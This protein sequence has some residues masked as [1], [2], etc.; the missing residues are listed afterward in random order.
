MPF[1]RLK[2]IILVSFFQ[3]LTLAAFAQSAP[4]HIWEIQ[5]NGT[6][7]PVLHQIVTTRVSIVTAVGSNCFFIQSPPQASDHDPLTS[8]GV[9]VF[10]GFRPGLSVG[11]SVVVTGIVQE[12]ETM[13]QIGP[14]AL[15]I[16]VDTSQLEMPQPI[17]F[18]DSFPGD[19]AMEVPALEAIEGMRVSFSALSTAPITANN[20]IPVSARMRRSFRE[21]GIRHPGM[22]DLPVWDGNPEVFWVAPNALGL[23][24]DRFVGAHATLKGSGVLQ[25]EGSRYVIWP[26]TLD[27]AAPTLFEP[28]AAPEEKA[29]T[30][31]SLNAVLLREDNFFLDDNLVKTA[32]YIIAGMRAPK[33]I[34]LQEIGN[35]YILDRLAATLRSLDPNLN[36]QPVFRSGNDNIHLAFL[37]DAALKIVEVQQIG[38]SE[39]LDNGQLLH[40][41]PPLLLELELPTDPATRLFVL[42]VHL[43]SLI[44]VDHPELG[45][46]V[47]NKRHAQGLSVAK[48]VQNY[49]G[50]NLVVLGDFNAYAFTDGY[51][52]VLGQITGRDGLG[53][54]VPM[55]PIVYP[56]LN[57]LSASLPD[58][59]QYSYNYEGNAE[60]LDHCLS[61]DLPDFRVIRLQYAR[62]NADNAWD[63]LKDP[64]T[65]YRSSDHDG[66]VLFLEPLR[67]ILSS[68]TNVN[69]TNTRVF[70][71]NPF[72]ADD[73]I[74]I[75]FERSG[76]NNALLFNAA[77][78]LVFHRSLKG[79]Q[80]VFQLPELP[81]GLYFLRISGP[82]QFM[83]KKL[84]L[85]QQ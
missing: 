13:T 17:V 76:N 79:K 12:Y 33:V 59:Q 39:R 37:V 65:P 56:Y 81:A 19:L 43:R 69:R 66:L 67:P 32:R 62:G 68:T 74:R 18:S 20:R 44:N 71:P 9:K 61:N 29:L 80:E 52:D 34:A 60:L 16:R 24:L 82:G 28:V 63:H 7:S 38:L 27:I 58:S 15:S 57:N 50:Q 55:E 25:A 47:R 8:D 64:S 41:R 22:S 48:V 46:Q 1:K 72:G 78:Q 6:Q 53:A 3:V 23:P 85:R 84:I 83:T 49:H 73:D 31:G 11:Q 75:F 70:F 4:L 21:P 35:A 26:Q 45:A 77:G 51:V 40:D 14:N 42:N 5:G 10:T 54:L 2:I 30:V 36:Y